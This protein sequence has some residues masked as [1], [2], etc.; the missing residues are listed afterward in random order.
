[1]P[2]LL[3]LQAYAFDRPIQYKKLLVY[4]V[5]MENYYEFQILVQSL[6]IEKNRTLEGIS[7][8]YLD[9]L[10][11]LELQKD[12]NQY[13]LKFDALLKMCLK[14]DD[15]IILN[16]YEYIDKEGKQKNPV[17]ILY[18]NETD[19]NA[20][21][22]GD[23]YDSTDFDKLRLMICGQNNVELPDEKISFEVRQSIEDAKRLRMRLNGTIPPTLE[24]EVAC[25]MA[26]TSLSV[27]DI[28]K[29]SIR[30]FEQ[31]IERIDKKL[32]YQIYM[33][34]AMSGMVEF[35]DKSVLKHWMSGNEDNT[36]K[37]TID[38]NDLERKM[39]LDDLKG[40]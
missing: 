23:R 19:A 3:T 32:H 1:M 11:T 10:Y 2:S 12:K 14:K 29:L 15:L 35:K 21:I 16:K 7:K 22:N 31:L 34:G 8:T 5:I 40:K 18:E 24:D 33:T 25:V 9:Y 17:F 38:L 20:N 36:F 39:S 28:A 30:K 27:D 37:E 26:S 6:L 4:P 13:L